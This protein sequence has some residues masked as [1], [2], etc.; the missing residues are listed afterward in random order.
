MINGDAG[1]APFPS[2]SVLL[3]TGTMGAGKST[4]AQLVAERLPRAAHVRGDVFLLDTSDQA[5]HETVEAIFGH[6]TEAQVAA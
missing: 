4:V 3:V 5:P 1:D 2:G 6:A